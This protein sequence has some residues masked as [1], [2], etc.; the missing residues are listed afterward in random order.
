MNMLI[1]HFI[2]GSRAYSQHHGDPILWTSKENLPGNEMK[3][4]IDDRISGKL[5]I[6]ETKGIVYEIKNLRHR[7]SINKELR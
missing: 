1:N 4:D 2:I 7:G 3:L 5:N 6:G